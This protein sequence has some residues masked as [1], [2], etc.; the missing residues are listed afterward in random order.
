MSTTKISTAHS[1]DDHHYA[2]DAARLVDKCRSLL[3]SI[4]DFAETRDSASRFQ[5]RRRSF[6][7]ET[8]ADGESCREISLG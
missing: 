5:F 1:N 2:I 3:H 8:L 4:L 6:Q 7:L